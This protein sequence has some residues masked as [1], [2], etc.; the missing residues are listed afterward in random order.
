MKKLIVSIGCTVAFLAASNVALAQGKGGGASKPKASTGS[1]KSGTVAHGGG[2]TTHASTT[3]SGPRMTAQGGTK[4]HGPTLKTTGGSQSAKAGG[5]KAK[6]TTTAKGTGPKTKPSTT[7]AKETGPK[8]KSTTTTTTA[9]TSTGKSKKETTTTVATG[10]TLTPVQQKLKRNTNLAKMLESRLPKGTDLMDAAA[11][12]RNLGQFVAAVNASFNHELDF[13]KLK[14]AMVD[15][16]MS[17]GQAMKDQRS[18]LDDGAEAVRIQREAD[19]MIRSTE[20]DLTTTSTTSTRK[21]AT[22]KAKDTRQ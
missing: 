1:A 16:G 10:E 13:D 20:P 22:A 9:S 8:T 19:V 6:S 12:F 14:T 5:P 18:S 4:A 17:L 3:T 11:D 2:K 21:P 7:T 15:D